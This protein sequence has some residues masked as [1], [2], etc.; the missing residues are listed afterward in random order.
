MKPGSSSITGLRHACWKHLKDK[1]LKEEVQNY[2]SL[3]PSIELAASLRKSKIL[4]FGKGKAELEKMDK[5]MK[6][7]EPFKQMHQNNGN[8]K[9]DE[10]KRKDADMEESI[11]SGSTQVMLYKNRE[12][13][14][15]RRSW[16]EKREEIWG[17]KETRGEDW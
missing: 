14:G 3:D 1:G 2:G 4:T 6:I 15:N 10:K 11:L 9:I 5:G 16:G 13:R 12:N 17:G 7:S 8:I